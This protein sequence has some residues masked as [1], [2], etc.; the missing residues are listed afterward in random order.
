[1]RTSLPLP[2]LDQLRSLFET[3][4]FSVFGQSLC[5]RQQVQ[6]YRDLTNR[7]IQ[8]A[9]NPSIYLAFLHL[10]GP[11]PPHVFNRLTGGFTLS[12]SPI[13][14]CTDSLAL[15]DRTLGEIRRAMETT[16]VWDHSVVLVAS[17]HHSTIVASV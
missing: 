12:N 10:H 3:P 14:G 13:R 5:L 9:V 4:N 2:T 8:L 17:D 6:N 1:M 16:G 7:A 15:T 11:H